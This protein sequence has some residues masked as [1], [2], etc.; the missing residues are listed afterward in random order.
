MD[1]LSSIFFCFPLSHGLNQYVHPSSVHLHPCQ[2]SLI[3]PHLLQRW[4]KWLQFPW[5]SKYS[6]DHDAHPPAS[7]HQ[8]FFDTSLLPR[9][10]QLWFVITGLNYWM[11]WPHNILLFPPTDDHHNAHLCYPTK[12]S[13]ILLDGWDVSYVWKGEKAA[14][15][16]LA[17]V[18]ANGSMITRIIREGKIETAY[19]KTSIM[20]N[21]I[22]LLLPHSIA[23]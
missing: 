6:Y 5:R 1:E 12:A 4:A 13:L 21:N 7:M 2:S 10:Y 20:G 17:K 11:T 9:A 3:I 8:F 23:L 16:K 15:G 14:A 18:G 22:E 19:D